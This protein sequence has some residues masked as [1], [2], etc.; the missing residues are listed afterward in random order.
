M[1]KHLGTIKGNRLRYLCNGSLKPFEEKITT[2]INKVNCSNCLR[3]N[4][5]NK[6]QNNYKRMFVEDSIHNLRPSDKRDEIEKFY[7]M[8][9]ASLYRFSMTC[10]VF[11]LLSWVIYAFFVKSQIL[12]LFSWLFLTLQIISALLYNSI[13]RKLNRMYEENTQ[14]INKLKRGKYGKPRRKRSVH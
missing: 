5:K 4:K 12:T 2:N 13:T 3:I 1:I 11:L 9:R 7:S 6:D 10:F 14:K 8:K